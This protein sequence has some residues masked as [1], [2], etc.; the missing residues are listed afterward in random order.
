MSKVTQ[1]PLQLLLASMPGLAGC[2]E[3]P[4]WEVTHPSKGSLSFRGKPATSASPSSP[5]KTKYRRFPCNAT[6]PSPFLP[7][8]Q[9]T[10]SP[11]IAKSRLRWCLI[12]SQPSGTCDETV[13]EIGLRPP[14]TLHT[15]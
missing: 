6:S 13:K 9:L 5:V 11:P 2:S 12:T 10:P 4:P 3:Q 1:I 8:F 15:R 14:R 7:E